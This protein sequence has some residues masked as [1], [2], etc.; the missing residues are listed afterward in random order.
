MSP[1]KA[2]PILKDTQHTL[3][4]TPTAT[5]R[6]AHTCELTH[7]RTHTPAEGANA[8]ACRSGVLSPCVPLM[9]AALLTERARRRGTERESL[10]LCQLPAQ[11]PRSSETGGVRGGASLLSPRSRQASP[12]PHKSLAHALCGTPS[13]PLRRGQLSPETLGLCGYWRCPGCTTRGA[14]WTENAP[15]PGVPSCLSPFLASPSLPKPLLAEPWRKDG[16][17]PCR[18]SLAWPHLPLGRAGRLGQGRTWEGP[19]KQRVDALQEGWV[20]KG[21]GTIGGRESLEGQCRDRTRLAG[22]AVTAIETQAHVA[23]EKT[24]PST[25]V[26]VKN[27]QDQL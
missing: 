13:L 8:H 1:Y 21:A 22:L 16:L 17:S 23:F 14:E 9:P 3:T 12:A 24:I 19:G 2:K 4:H 7:A 18:R 26:S 5:D 11:P 6:Q 25:G 10:P 27:L 15:Q 20:V